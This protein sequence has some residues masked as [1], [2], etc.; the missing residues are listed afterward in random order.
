MAT[1][2]GQMVTPNSGSGT[3]GKQHM[4]PGGFRRP[5]TPHQGGT[6][7]LQEI[8]LFSDSSQCLLKNHRP[9]GRAAQPALSPR[10]QS[11]GSG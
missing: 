6:P 8:L 7:V 10:L 1:L 4:L 5:Q 9:L 3:T 11:V 2:Q